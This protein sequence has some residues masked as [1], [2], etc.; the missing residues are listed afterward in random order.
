MMPLAEP[1]VATDEYLAKI[2]YTSV[3]EKDYEDGR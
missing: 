3:R 1:D 2:L